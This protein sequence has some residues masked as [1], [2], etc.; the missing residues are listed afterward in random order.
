MAMVPAPVVSAG[1]RIED[2]RLTRIAAAAA[3]VGQIADTYDPDYDEFLDQTEQDFEGYSTEM[4]REIAVSD[5]DSSYLKMFGLK[6]MIE[7][8]ADTSD[9]RDMLNLIHVL[10]NNDEFYEP[11]EATK[12]ISSLKRYPG[13]EP[14]T[15]AEGPYP[16]LRK[17]Q[18][19]AILRV[20][21]M[22]DELIA[23][24]YIGREA[25]PRDEDYGANV[26]SNAQLVE[27]VVSNPDD[28]DAILEFME[29]RKTDDV[30]RIK[31]SL[32]VGNRDIAA[33]IL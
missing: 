26:L 3:Y 7:N 4:L 20:Y 33:G 6:H 18:C 19:E 16:E 22:T 32:Y 15:D 29:E 21:N 25:A 24:E 31:E 5:S 28:I 14:L 27:L 11:E 2:H 13:V 8:D 12:V 23:D 17:Q 1:A 10:A 30:D 9:M